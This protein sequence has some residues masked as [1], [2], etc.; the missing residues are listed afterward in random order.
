MLDAI[1]SYGK[2]PNNNDK[3]GAEKLFLWNL[4]AS[5]LLSLLLLL[6]HC[7][8]LPETG[9]KLGNTVML[10]DLPVRGMVLLLET[11]RGVHGE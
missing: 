4:G 6:M 5:S 3:P 8:V 10:R 7:A 1:A 11:D 2:I 9:E